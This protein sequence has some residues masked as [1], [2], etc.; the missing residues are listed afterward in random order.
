M[1]QPT[2]A[3]EMSHDVL[4]IEPART[5]R[6]AARE[7]TRH[8]C[9][10]V[11]VV[12]PEQPGPGIVTERD[13]SRAVGNGKDPTKELVGDHVATN[14]SYASPDWSLQAAAEAMRDGGFRHLVVIDG[15]DLVGVLSIRDVVRRWSDERS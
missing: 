9:G 12:D 5:L 14:A 2:V 1:S 8:N 6:E 11:V 13:V 4:T 15:T 7:M 10:A 3:D